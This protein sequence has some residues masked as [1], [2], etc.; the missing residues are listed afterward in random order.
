[1]NK[2]VRWLLIVDGVLLLYTFFYAYVVNLNMMLKVGS[3]LFGLSPIYAITSF[4][5]LGII[6]IYSGITGKINMVGRILSGITALIV[7]L[8]IFIQGFSIASAHGIL[9]AAALPG[10][11]FAGG[12]LIHII[13]EHALGGGLGFILAVKPSLLLKRILGI[14]NKKG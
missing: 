6:F 4:G 8:F 10:F 11:P 1:M 2:Y 7:I 9:A 12:L 13:F 14:Q 3:K 5:I